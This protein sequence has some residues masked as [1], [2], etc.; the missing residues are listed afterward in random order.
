MSKKTAKD[1]YKMYL[2]AR[3]LDS[4]RFDDYTELLAYYE[5]EEGNL[6]KNRTIKP[7]VININ[8]PYAADAINLRM[9][10]FFSKDYMGELEPLSPYDTEKIEKL[11][12]V[13]HNFWK[14]MNLDNHVNQAINN[15]MVLRESYTH[16][17]YEDKIV[18][19]TNTKRN[20]RLIAYSIDPSSVLIDPDALNFKDAEYIIVTD[21]ITQKEFERKYGKRE[22]VKEEFASTFQPSERGEIYVGKDYNTNQ[23]NIKTRLTFYEKSEDETILKIVLV[24]NEIVDEMELPIKVFPIAQLRYERKTKSPYGLSLMDRLLPLQKSINAIESATT[25]AALAFASPSYAVRR[26]SGVD[27]RAVAALAGSPGVVFTVVGDPETAIKPISNGKIDSNLVKIKQENRE[28]LYRLSGI[29]EEFL[30]NFGSSGN[31][32]GGSNLATQRAQIV[33]HKFFDNLEAYIEDLTLIIIEFITK[34]FDGETIFARS[35]QETT[36]EYQFQEFDITADMKN[37]DYTFSI[38]MDIKTPYAKENVK[39]VLTEIYQM[40]RQYDAPVKTINVLDIIKQYNI[41]NSQELVNRYKEIAAKDE[42]T[43]AD[44]ITQWVALCTESGVPLDVI[45][46]GIIELMAGKEIPTVEQVVAQLEQ[47][48]RQQEQQEIQRQQ[49][50][51]AQQTQIANKQMAE[52]YKQQMAMQQQ[53][54]Q[55]Q[56]FTGDEILN[57]EGEPQDMGDAVFNT[58]QE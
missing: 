28:E 24:E 48:S 18:G 57:V 13:Y 21:R 43:K 2:E 31:T 5:M 25:T 37:L 58:V 19:G 49:Q 29:S 14:E 55:G 42:K 47:Q 38:N 16:I 12:D 45:T 7:W 27:P 36:G 1:Y 30:G 56:Q 22:E 33:E 23:N 52:Q 44:A 11:N 6:P 17:V 10:S 50:L 54:E 41:P 26:D 15:C 20:G 35:E 40:E 51:A 32:S 8:T 53:Q 9:A 46:Q 34:A 4:E 3:E 39:R